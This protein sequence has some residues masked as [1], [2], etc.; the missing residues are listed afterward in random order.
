M[1]LD[2]KS[3]A[4]S[5]A[6]DHQYSKLYETGSLNVRRLVARLDDGC[7]FVRPVQSTDVALSLTGITAAV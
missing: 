2:C 3:G 4:V 6:A 1:D 5:E 7:W